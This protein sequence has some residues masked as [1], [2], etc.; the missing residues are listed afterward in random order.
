LCKH[1][2]R[3]DIHA[4]ILQLFALQRAE[5]DSSPEGSSIHPYTQ[6]TSFTSS[7]IHPFITYILASYRVIR[8][9]IPDIPGH[10][11]QSAPA[12]LRSIQLTFEGDR[13]EDS[14]ESAGRHAEFSLA[15][16]ADCREHLCSE[17]I[18]IPSPHMGLWVRYSLTHL[19][20]RFSSNVPSY[21]I[22]SG[23]KIQLYLGFVS[24]ISSSEEVNG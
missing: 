15:Y 4:T 13:K 6:Y 9:E 1:S 17:S 23:S 18:R 8:R 21:R 11:Y 10:F 14:L 12:P 24:A 22:M 3:F 19:T 2:D 5:F 16:D 20:S 7:S